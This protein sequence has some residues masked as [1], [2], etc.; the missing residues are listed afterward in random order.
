MDEGKI[1]TE[2]EQS[3]GSA[4]TRSWRTHMPVASKP[5]GS[6][7]ICVAQLGPVSNSQTWYVEYARVK[8]NSG[9][10][11]ALELFK[12]TI[13]DLH[14]IDSTAVGNDNLETPPTPGIYLA[15][16]EILIFKWTGASLNAVGVVNA[17][18]RVFS[19]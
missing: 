1:T 4:P 8:N 18:V 9:T 5:A 11:T 6:D 2:G 14:S 15:E 19:G 16:G 17:Q 10:P 3:A 13:D 7:G 12:N